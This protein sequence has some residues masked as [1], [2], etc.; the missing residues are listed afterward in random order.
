MQMLVPF[1]LIGGI[2]G[3]KR[4]NYHI[5]TRDTRC[6][7]ILERKDLSPRSDARVVT[8]SGRPYAV[9][10][11]MRRLMDLVHLLFNEERV[12][13]TTTSYTY[14]YGKVTLH[15]PSHFANVL[16]SRRDMVEEMVEEGG[17]MTIASFEEMP[18]G[19]TKRQVQI[20]GTETEV[21]TA[22]A[23]LDAS[24]QRHLIWRRKERIEGDEVIFK[25][26]VANSDMMFIQGQESATSQRLAT[27]FNV[28]I[29][30][31]PVRKFDKTI[32]TISGLEDDVVQVQMEMALAITAKEDASKLLWTKSGPT[33]IK[34]SPDT[35][36]RISPH[37]SR[38]HSL[39]RR[40]SRSRSN[41]QF[42]GPRRSSQT[43]S[44]RRF[45]HS[46]SHN[47][48]DTE[49]GEIVVKT[50]PS[51]IVPSTENWDPNTVGRV[52]IPTRDPRLMRNRNQLQTPMESTQEIIYIKSEPGVDDSTP[53][54][55]R[56][57]VNA[58]PPVA[59]PAP[60]GINSQQVAPST[61]PARIPLATPISQVKQPL[62]PKHDQVTL[63]TTPVR[64]SSN[65]QI[66]QTKQPLPPKQPRDEAFIK[67]EPIDPSTIA[68]PRQATQAASSSAQVPQNASQ[69]AR[70]NSTRQPS[71]AMSSNIAVQHQQ[72]SSRDSS[73]GRI[74]EPRIDQAN[75]GPTVTPSSNSHA[76][77][78]DVITAPNSLPQSTAP[79]ASSV[80][81]TG[82]R[83]APPD[84]NEQ[85]KRPMNED[86]APAA[87]Q[88][89]STQELIHD[90]DE[91]NTSVKIYVPMNIAQRIIAHGFRKLTFPKTIIK[92]ESDRN[93]E[94][95]V[96]ITIEGHWA[97]T[98][99]AQNKIN[100]LSQ[101][102]TKS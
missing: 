85:S 33:I 8:I 45:S 31:S 10:T 67:E 60:N 54:P 52:T 88:V 78:N 13:P 81:Q 69:P 77:T 64:A 47:D 30:F 62:P 79:Q 38:Q 91:Q 34:T 59:I 86:T 35:D 23:K 1:T 94:D 21:H 12:L 71:S 99:A 6:R 14:V 29:Q 49:E 73:V 18:L 20:F 46:S 95:F 96:V 16:S 63:N 65:A 26:L 55:K 76:P 90:M 43:S 44:S 84:V 28:S 57:P 87:A 70:D 92:F 82:K 61:T 32:V 89:T 93:R 9:Q 50:E 15:I 51:A 5:I 66:P 101:Q 48:E 7:V 19:A 74:P 97:E 24:L 98:L 83:K 37:S 4:D 42:N 27:R 36:D 58:A 17:Q 75:K 40:D 11:A 22:I 3:D 68:P 72:I 25:A 39:D 41:E 53:V 56:N 100:V 2:V 80:S 102:P